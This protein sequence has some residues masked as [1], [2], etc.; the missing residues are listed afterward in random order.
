MNEP[1]SSILGFA[2][3]GKDCPGLPEQAERDF[4]KVIR[5]SLYAHEV[6]RKLM[7]FAGQMPPQKTRVNLNQVVDDA[8]YFLESQCTKTGIRVVRELAPG[9]SP[10]ASTSKPT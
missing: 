4:E 5:A 9:L 7:V 3:L 6:I 8:L 2:Q 1:L 10:P